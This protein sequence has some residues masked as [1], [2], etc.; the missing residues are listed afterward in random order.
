MD[1]RRIVRGTGR[2]FIGAGVLGLLFV[3]Y[4]LWGTGF[5]ERRSQHDLRKQFEA[6]TKS[7]TTTTDIPVL[8][9]GTSGVTTTVPPVAVTAPP[10]GDAVAIINIDKIGV[11]KAVVEGVGLG[12]LRKGPGHY[13][14]TPLP[15][16]AGNAAIA[17]HRTTYGAPFFRLDELHDG[18]AIAIT[19][20]GGTYHYVVDK[21]MIVKPTDVSVLD[22][23]TA[24]HLTL[25]TCNPRFSASQR[26]VVQAALRDAPAPTAPTTIPVTAPGETPPTTLAS[27]E[28][29]NLAGDSTAWLPTI[30]FGLAAL[31]VGIG[32]WLVG[33]AWRKWP[34][35]V[36]GA[37]VLLLVLFFLF[38]NVNRLLPSNV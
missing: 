32:I 18:D 22:T 20:R 28:S 11:H 25:T 21:T 8:T 26:L 24:P 16:Q 33:R 1:W 6:A 27:E 37:P 2:V 3:A 9:P 5:A 15:G 17:G 23:T 4:Q 36:L 19:T 38:E 12:D 30:L 34:A 10:A 14:G 7:S 35:Y 13:P 29:P 31:A